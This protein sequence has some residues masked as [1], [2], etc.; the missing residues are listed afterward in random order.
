MVV[1][2]DQGKLL[3]LDGDRKVRWEISDLQFPLDAQFLPGNRVLVAENQGNRITERNLKGEVLWEHKTEQP[4]VAQRLPSGNTFIGTRFQLLEVDRDGR[5][6]FA[7]FPPA[8]QEIMRAQRL[9]NGDIVYVSNARQFVRL[10]ASGKEIQSFGV[11]V[12]TSGGRI[13]VL[14]DG[15]VLV[16]QRFNNRVVEQD[17]DGKIHWQAEIPEPIMGLR[18]ANGN[19]LLTSLTQQRAVEV[20]KDGKE[21]WEY[22]STESRVTRAWRR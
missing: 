4:L 2:L 3:E 18:L 13:D 9:R 20:D 19:T 17:A 6:V 7:H 11:E 21:V 5:Q 14:P 10:D 15:R 16:P 12:Y 8:G 1:L 22:K